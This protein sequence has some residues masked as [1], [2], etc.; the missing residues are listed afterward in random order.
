MTAARK[1]G[2]GASRQRRSNADDRS[3]VS[4]QRWTLT[5]RRSDL[6]GYILDQPH[7]LKLF[8]WQSP[9]RCRL[10]RWI[11]GW[12]E[13]SRISSK[14]RR[15]AASQNRASADPPEANT[16]TATAPTET[17]ITTAAQVTCH[18]HRC[19]EG[20]RPRVDTCSS[21]SS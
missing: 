15:L 17:T 4:G 18:H 14:P 20:A 13:R 11:E 3:G 21:S 5:S 6:R 9:C 2:D 19:A 7:D 8:E 10:L 12:N 16:P 1:S